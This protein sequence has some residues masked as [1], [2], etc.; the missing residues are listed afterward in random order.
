MLTIESNRNKLFVISCIALLTT[1]MTFGLRANMIG[2]LGN[3]FQISKENMGWIAGTAFWG[4]TVSMLIGGFL[5]DKLGMK[6][7]LI[8]AFVCHI[9]GVLLTIFSVGYYSLFISTLLIGLANGFVEA[10]CNPLVATLYP[11]QKT[12]KLNQF[13]VWFPL[14]IVIGGLIGYFSN[15]IGWNWQIQLTAI[16]IPATVYGISILGLNFPQTERIT[17][18]ISNKTMMSSL[19]KPFFILMV[20][21]MLLTA[22]TELGTNQ[23]I[24]ELLKNVVPNSI[25]VL[26]FIN[27]IMAG[28]RMFA[29]SLIHQ[30]STLGT[31]LF[32]A[33]FACL[34]LFLLS[35]L[36][37][38]ACFLG[39]GVFAIGICFF[40]PTMLGFISEKIPE[41]GAMG[42][43]VMGAAGMLS[44]SFILPFLGKVYDY[45]L[46]SL[47]SQELNESQS[48]LLAGAD[49][50]RSVAL[51]PAVLI[52]VFGVLFLRSRGKG[53]EKRWNFKN[54]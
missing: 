52:L 4:F 19:A 25:L 6:K 8:T 32:S 38:Y 22:S 18:G 42:L 47:A 17:Q 41:S 46:S 23:W 37:G 36:N 43:S 40:W 30:I 31:L 14:G 33:V 45:N 2:D 35:Y 5:C 24:A 21:C 15:Q 53:M 39:A 28:G 51:L 12:K 54:V 11:D 7:L 50:L 3:T 49:T 44:V 27:L 10:A 29:G 26:V 13:H 20:A 34:G 16:L 9:A 48:A 1:S